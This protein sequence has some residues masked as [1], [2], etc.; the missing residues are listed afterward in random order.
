MILEIEM[1]KKTVKHTCMHIAQ[2]YYQT[3]NAQCTMHKMNI[4]HQKKEIHVYTRINTEN[5]I[6]SFFFTQAKMIQSMKTYIKQ[7]R[8]TGMAFKVNLNDF[9]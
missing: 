6:H 5:T 8:K 4:D 1:R 2:I 9:I 3:D 7:T